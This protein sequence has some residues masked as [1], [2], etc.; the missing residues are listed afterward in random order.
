[1]PLTLFS[2]HTVL[3]LL[4]NKNFSLK[5]YRVGLFVSSLSLYPQKLWMLAQRLVSQRA[6]EGKLKKKKKHTH[7]LAAGTQKAHAYVRT[8]MCVQQVSKSRES[9]APSSSS[10]F[11]F[12]WRFFF[13]VKVPSYQHS[14][15][16][17]QTLLLLL[18]FDC[19]AWG[20][21]DQA[22]D[23]MT[24]TVPLFAPSPTLS[25]LSSS[26]HLC[27]VHTNTHLSHRHTHSLTLFFSCS[28]RRRT[29]S[30]LLSLF[31]P[32][33]VFFANKGSHTTRLT[34]VVPFSVSPGSQT[35]L[36]Q[37]TKRSAILLSASVKRKKKR[38]RS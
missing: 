31:C 38:T 1:M 32:V 17:T 7:T 15:W 18:L 26:S 16:A 12:V 6:E 29:S 35:S 21:W 34:V 10:S 3:S 9:I 4:E 33:Q 28:L 11:P 13:G 24:G 8:Y 20:F 2:S 22:C 27:F 36:L 19:A 25:L 30:C 14:L 23:W 37:T 5:D